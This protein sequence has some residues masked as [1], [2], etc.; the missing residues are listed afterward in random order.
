ME[1]TFY[2]NGI[3]PAYLAIDPGF[4]PEEIAESLAYVLD[5][6]G[7]KLFKRNGISTALIA[8]E[9]VSGVASLRQRTDFT[10]S[11]L[12]LDLV[13]KVTAWFEAVYRKHRSEAV[14]YLYY[15]PTTGEWDFI[16]PTQTATGASADY[17]SAPKREGWQVV[18]TIHS[19]GSMSAFHSG[20]DD[21][22]EQHFDGVH[23]TVGKVDSVPEYSCSIVVQGQRTTF[24]PHE[25]IDGMAP[26]NAIP[27]TWLA[28]VKE[29]AP[30]GLLAS[31]QTQ[32]DKLY[33]AYYEGKLSEEQYKKDL[34]ELK[35]KEEAQRERE[36]KS[37]S[38]AY[39]QDNNWDEDGYS[40]PSSP[41]R[42]FPLSG[43]KKTGTGGNRGGKKKKK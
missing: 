17:E 36:R 38:L 14:G 8:V 5:G 40:R 28:A 30:R 4:D 22:D 3:F 21:R 20:T 9:S 19:H 16:P 25:L 23:L 39:A 41:S 32:A 15:Q 18:G 35:K 12:P 6:Q 10:A 37:Q 11:K 1:P 7:W 27:D 26:A 13:R 29:S 34:A 24:Q 31:F 43:I 42:P 2:V 33:T